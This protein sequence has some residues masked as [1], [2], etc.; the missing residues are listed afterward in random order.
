MELAHFILTNIE[1]ILMEW[2]S[3][4]RSLEPGKTMTR[5]AL[6]GDAE[7]ILRATVRDMAATQSVSEQ[8]SKSKGHGG[9]GGEASDGLDDASALHGLGRI[10]SGFDIVEVVS[11]YR[12]LRASVLRQWRGSLPHPTAYDIADII[13]FNE[14]MDQSLAIAVGSYTRRVDKSRRMFLAILSHDLRN[15]LNCI[16][17]AARLGLQAEDPSSESAKTLAVIETYTRDISLLINDMIDF[18]STGL[19]N[20]MWLTRGPVDLEKLCHEVLNGFH[21]MH[22][23]RTIRFRHEGDLTGLWDV[24][25]LQ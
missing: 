24:M 12:S 10:G 20:E 13:H 18:A 6:R 23:Q 14:S 15:P 25:R 4:A 2:E 9:A 7:M 3:F 11:E 21:L 8:S 16:R 22:P 5:L 1:P 17:M 19:G